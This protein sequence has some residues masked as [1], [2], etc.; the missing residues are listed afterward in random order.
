MS[1]AQVEADR[2]FRQAVHDLDAARHT[3]RGGFYFAACFHAQQAAEKALKACRYAQGEQI[4]LGHSVF[5]L[6]EAC[7]TKDPRFAN[8]AHECGRLDTF[9]IPTRYPN[10]LPESIPAEVYTAA[11]ADLALQLAQRVIDLVRKV[12]GEI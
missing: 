12:L 8:L 4:V 3:A 5:R 7:G 11:D 2:W 1:K 6:A 9:Y 10:G